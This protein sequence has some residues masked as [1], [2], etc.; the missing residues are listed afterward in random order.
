[1]TTKTRLSLGISTVIL[2]LGLA[3]Q[4]PSLRTR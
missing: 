2:T 1:M 4:P 3:L